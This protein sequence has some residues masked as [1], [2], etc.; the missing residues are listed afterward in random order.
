MLTIRVPE[1]MQQ[2]ACR[3]HR[4]NFAAN[5]NFLGDEIVV[6]RVLSVLNLM[7]KLGLQAVSEE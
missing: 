1:P 2:E 4:D 7:M 5:D 3:R 6:I